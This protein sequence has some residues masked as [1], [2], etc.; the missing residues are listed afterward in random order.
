MPSKVSSTSKFARGSKNNNCSICRED[1]SYY[2]LHMA[3]DDGEVDWVFPCINPKEVVS[4]FV[5]K[6]LALVERSSTDEVDSE[7]KTID[8]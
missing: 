7:I 8:R 5:F 6:L 1:V 2:G 3:E 4:K